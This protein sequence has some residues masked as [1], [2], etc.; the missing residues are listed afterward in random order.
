[1]ISTYGLIGSFKVLYFFLKT[2]IFF[3]NARLVRFPIDIRNKKNIDFG[4]N[5]TTGFGCRI[6]CFPIK[7]TDDKLLKFGKN[8]Q[9]N[10]YVHITAAHSVEIGNNVLMASKIYISDCSH[11]SYIGNNDDSDPRI[12]PADRP[13]SVKPV[14]IQDNVWLGEFVSVLPGVTIGEGTIVGANSVVSKSLP[15]YVIAVGSP[16]KPIK[17][18]NFDTQKWEKY[19]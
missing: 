19:V 10:D 4:V 14:K 17:F 6:E 11:G 7:P 15:S 8:V 3:S 5:L 18:Y 16:A 1:M 2:K 13:L 9:L 12:I